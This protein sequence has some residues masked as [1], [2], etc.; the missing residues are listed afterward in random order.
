M[1]NETLEGRLIAQR[2]VLAHLVR[3]HGEEVQKMMRDRA[4]V[5]VPEE[6]PGSD[7]PDAAFAIEAALADEMRL[8]LEAVDRLG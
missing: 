3:A 1:T 6:D 8:I 5:Q 2:M 4:T 7:G